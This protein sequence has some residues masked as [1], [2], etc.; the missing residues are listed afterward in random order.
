[1]DGRRLAAT[2]ATLALAA[3]GMGARAEVV[4][5]QRCEA[6]MADGSSPQRVAIELTDERARDVAP[7]VARAAGVRI[8]GMERLAEARITLNFACVEAGTIVAILASESKLPPLR[9]G[10]DHYAFGTAGQFAALAAIDSRV[11]TAREEGDDAAL[12][13]A[14]REYVD[15]VP[16]LTSGPAMDV[17]DELDEAARL[18]AARDDFATAEALQRR[19]IAVVSRVEGTPDAPG[20]MAALEQVATLRSL[21]GDDDGANALHRE[22]LAMAKRVPS[23]DAKVVAH[24]ATALGIDA[25]GSDATAAERWFAIATPILLRLEPSDF[26]ALTSSNALMAHALVLEQVGRLDEAL[27]LV[28]RNLEIQRAHYDANDWLVGSAM[29]EVARVLVKRDE[30]ERAAQ[31]YDSALAIRRAAKRIDSPGGDEARRNA[32]A[33]AAL[34]PLV[35][36]EPDASAIVAWRERSSTQA[37]DDAALADAADLLQ[38]RAARQRGTPAQAT[39]C[40]GYAE[41]VARRVRLGRG[42]MPE[43]LAR[44]TDAARRECLRADG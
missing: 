35:R 41:I 37:A 12:S 42:G 43:L 40:D 31:L 7:L 29:E 34:G 5:V 2:F 16:M 9:E 44:A 4:R 28:E 18:A 30:L 21:Q 39:T 13:A 23:H 10:R 24:A 25:L 8:D 33:I 38:A 19:R 11:S 1:M 20:A 32:A 14:L 26:D 36:R 22:V 27:P 6:E 17:A 15:A 3:L